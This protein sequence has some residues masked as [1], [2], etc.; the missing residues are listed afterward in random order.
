MK[1]RWVV[2]MKPSI[3]VSTPYF[4][5]TNPIFLEDGSESASSL[6]STIEDAA[7][8]KT[9]IEAQG[10]CAGLSVLWK[11]RCF[12]PEKISLMKWIWSWR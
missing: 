6:F 3:S 12:F 4:V 1:G 10:A 7:R 11:D 8:F 9:E 5:E 2:R